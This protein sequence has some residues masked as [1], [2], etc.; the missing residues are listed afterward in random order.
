MLEYWSPATYSFPANVAFRFKLDTDLFDLAKDKAVPSSMVV[1]RDGQYLLVMASDR[2]IRVFSF[3]TGKL[4]RKYNETL[5]V[6]GDLQKR[7]QQLPAMEFGRRI[8]K[9]REMDKVRLVL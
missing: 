9:E 3:A 1:S 6:L 8:A 5:A 7:K 4:F 2:Q